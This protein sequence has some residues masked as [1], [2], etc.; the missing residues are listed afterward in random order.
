[1]AP[2]CRRATP[3]TILWRA[4][5]AST[6]KAAI[7]DASSSSSSSKKCSNHSVCRPSGLLRDAEA[8]VSPS[9]GRDCPGLGDVVGA[10]LVRYLGVNGS[11]GRFRIA[12]GG[13]G[14]GY[15]GIR[16]PGYSNC[17]N[18]LQRIRGG[19][20]NC[21]FRSSAVVCAK[22]KVGPSGSTSGH[23]YKGKKNQQVQ[24]GE[25]SVPKVSVAMERQAA[26]VAAAAAQ[27]DVV[28]EIFEGIPV[29]ELAFQLKQPVDVVQTLL[30]GF[31]ESVGQTV[32]ADAAELAALEF[33]MSVKK[34]VRNRVQEMG[35]EGAEV[36]RSPV[37]TVMGHV[38]HGKTTL[39][40]ALRQTSVAA[41]EA[42]GITQH[43]GAFVVSMPSGGTLTFLDTPGHAAF[44]SMRARG[45]AV[46]DI[47]VLV[48]AADDG[49]MPQ[50][51]E[52][53]NLAQEAGVPMVVA[54]TK[55][56]R[57]EANPTRVRQQLAAEGLEL[58]EIGGDI[59]VV[60]V[61]ATANSGLEKL[62]EAL[63]LQAELMELR[64]CASDEL[65]AVVVEARVDRGRGPLATVVVRSGNLVPGAIVVV[66][67]QWGR[68]RALRDMSGHSVESA[69]PA[70]PVEIDGLRGLPEAGDYIQVVGSEERARKLSQC[71]R[72]RAEQKRLLQLKQ[73]NDGVA[74]VTPAEDGAEEQISE[75]VELTLIV[76]ADVQ[77]T[78]EA[79]SQALSQLSS[80]Q[81]GVNIIL[82]GVGPV[83]K[84]D[85][86]L[87]ESCNAVIVGFNVGAMKC[88]IEAAARLAKVKVLKHR[89]IYHLL[90]DVGSLII[91]MAPGI[92]E[93]QVAGQAEVLNVFELK[94]KG[95]NGKGATKI[96]GCRVVDGRLQ[97]S[98]RIRVLR[99][100]ELLFEG[101]MQS[102]K[103]EQQDVDTVSKGIECGM[104]VEEWV[105]FEV[106][107]VV[108][109]I[110]D[111][112]RMPKFVSSQNGAAR[113]EC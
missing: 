101:L 22:T 5:T 27:A 38:D 86:D 54:L 95:R 108:Q 4:S 52:A 92:K 82:S 7:N 111:F 40:D 56:D 1:M 58:E 50:T 87:A 96:A 47:V 60:E 109:C 26:F 12:R 104:I 31:G 53:M 34:V 32:G 28:V 90:E 68:L 61:S 19:S 14:L 102:L 77:G 51:L 3:L 64:A 11:L 76:K 37:V 62:E 88:G 113:I 46:T 99:S 110:T 105:N 33:G 45:T 43:L 65:H 55:C 30:A 79:V 15:D 85:V 112:R 67:T 59:Q 10:S 94:G 63:L 20:H 2:W 13:L 49:V 6:K 91:G 107:D 100:G 73:R 103:R 29:A 21:G 57:V 23:R 42:G 17:N 75:K 106:G 80:N 66:G 98:S 84:S 18:P 48:V 70:T 89:V 81:V 41:R 78:S 74:A 39:L 9:V 97:R 44:S 24:D 83:S 69:G 25:S 93:C 71:R 35:G 72:I 16:E 8:V 36:T